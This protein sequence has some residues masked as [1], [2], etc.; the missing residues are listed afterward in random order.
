MPVAAANV[1]R[2]QQ[3]HLAVD[4]LLEKAADALRAGDSSTGAGHCI[5][6]RKKMPQSRSLP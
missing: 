5:P 4:A 3:A 6:L 2:L 1:A